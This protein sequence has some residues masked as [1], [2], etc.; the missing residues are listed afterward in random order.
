MAGAFTAVDLSRLPYPDAVESLDF[1]TILNAMVE[2]LKVRDPVFTALVESDPAYKVME[3]C[4]YRELLMRQRVNEAVKAVTLAYA[5]G[6]DL[7]NI[8]ATYSVERLLLE[9]GDPDLIPP[10]PDVY[11]DDTSLRRRVQL[12]FEGFSTAG[13]EGSYIFHALG[14]DPDVLDVRVESPEPGAVTVA[15]LSRVGSGTASPELRAAVDATLNADDVRPLTDN[16][17]VTAGGV[18]EYTVVASLVLYDGPDSAVVVDAATTAVQLYADS[19]HRLGRNVTRAGIIAALF[20]EGVQNVTLTTPSAD[21][22]TQWDEAS[23]CTDIDITV[24]GT[25]E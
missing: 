14:A 2:D 10:T 4:A 7:D 17:T 8:A 11:E 9:A 13:P 1:E 23:Y 12:S 5:T 25:D 20:Q 19:V 22:V 16:V 15:V 24:S 18:I 3:V 6:A 21:I